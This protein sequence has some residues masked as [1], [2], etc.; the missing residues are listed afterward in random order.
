MSAKPLFFTAES[1]REAGELLERAIVLDP[2]YAQAYPHLR[3]VAQLPDRRG[4]VSRIRDADRAR[5]LSSRGARWTHSEDAFVLHV[6]R[7]ILS[8]PRQESAQA[9]RSTCSNRPWRSTR[10]RPSQLGAGRLTTALPRGCREALERLQNV[11]RVSIPFF[12]DPLNF[13]F[14]I[15]A[16]IAQFVAGRYGEAIAWLRKCKRANPRFIACLR[17]VAASLAC[18]VMRWARVQSRKSCLPSSL[19]SEFCSGIR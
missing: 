17:S 2:P 8:F 14:W 13:Y 11:F 19:H 15:V 4:L 6:G 1:Y 10:T 9:R 18:R 16:G 3:L 7:H 12:S 5:A